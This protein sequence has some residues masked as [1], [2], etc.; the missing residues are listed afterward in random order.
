MALLL[1]LCFCEHPKTYPLSKMDA[2]QAMQ[3]KPA[4]WHGGKIARTHDPTHSIR[5]KT[6]VMMSSSSRPIVSAV[7]SGRSES[8]SSAR[9]CQVIFCFPQQHWR[10]GRE[11]VNHAHSTARQLWWRRSPFHTPGIAPFHIPYP[12]VRT[13][14]SRC[15]NLL[16]HVHRDVSDVRHLQCRRHCAGSCTTAWR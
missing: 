8:A 13:G 2:T 4:K 3:S 11:V 9:N 1:M 6:A 10:L 5:S 16:A 7:S 15:P 12:R 14:S